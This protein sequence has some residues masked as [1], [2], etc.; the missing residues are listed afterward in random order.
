MGYID[1]KMGLFGDIMPHKAENPAVN[2]VSVSSS[3]A[4]ATYCLVIVV[5]VVGSQEL[6]FTGRKGRTLRSVSFSSRMESA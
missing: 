6:D 1:L 4:Y 5:T 3:P 2:R